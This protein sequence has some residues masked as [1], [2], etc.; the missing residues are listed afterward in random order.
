MN[1]KASKSTTG[2]D[3]G[4][5]KTNLAADGQR[6][7]LLVKADRSRCPLR[8]RVWKK[9]PQRKHNWKVIPTIAEAERHK[10]RAARRLACKGDVTP[11]RKVH[12]LDGAAHPRGPQRKLHKGQK[13]S[14]AGG[15]EGPKHVFSKHCS[16]LRWMI[17]QK[18]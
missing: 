7:G 1:D 6:V 15:A 9:K 12:Q 16:N 10:R 14:A 8:V 11:P 18:R 17:P 2:D 3:S 4:E 13:P 5:S